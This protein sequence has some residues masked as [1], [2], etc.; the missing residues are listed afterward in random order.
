VAARTIFPMRL[1][2]MYLL[3]IV[4]ATGREPDAGCGFLRPADGHVADRNSPRKE[5]IA[6]HLHPGR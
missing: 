2:F 5:R 4:R 6:G 3:L 1:R